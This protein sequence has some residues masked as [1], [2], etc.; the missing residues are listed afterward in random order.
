MVHFIFV[1]TFSRHSITY[2][3]NSA[4]AHKRCGCH[5]RAIA[6]RSLIL[7]S[8]AK[9]LPVYHD[10]PFQ[11]HFFRIGEHRLHYL[12]EGQGPCVVMVHGN[13][14]WSYYFR[15]LVAGLRG[16]HRVIAVDHLGC[17]LSDKPGDYSYTLSN[18]INNLKLL[19][20]H[21]YIDSCSLVVHDWG[22]AIGIGYAVS[23]P[24]KI[25]RIAVMNTAAFRS[26]RMPWRIRFCRLPV[27]G[28]IL[29]RLLNGFAWPA[30]FMAVTKAMP[31][32]VRANYLRPYDS[33]RNRVAI[34][35][36][37]KDIPMTRD[38]RSYGTLVKIEEGLEELRR[39]N[40]PLYI[41][42]AGKDFCFNDSFY[43]EWRKRFPEAQHRYFAD[44]GHYLLED[45][46]EEILPLLARFFAAK[47]EIS[48]EQEA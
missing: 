19:L 3:F 11:S 22:G 15:H 27:V 4:F 34:A 36:F 13:P 46:K 37:V 21:L 20:E 2:N 16:T 30:T 6:A 45:R 14:T 44:A 24:H 32:E 8:K 12:D 42:W 43:A 35:A 28:D 38:H 17:G 39:L 41:L 23:H 5:Q 25:D 7:V 10:Y 48:A 40:I 9:K 29:V 26:Q 31:G 33:W 18:H 1:D 47:E